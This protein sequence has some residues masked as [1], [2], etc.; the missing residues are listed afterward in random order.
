M[1]NETFNT[2]I[3]T[4]RS[5][6]ERCPPELSADLVDRGIVLAG[7]GALI[8]GLDIRMSQ[9]TGLPCIVAENAPEAVARGTG[10]VLDDLSLWKNESA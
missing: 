3:E 9:A 8:R 2:I 10:A 7:G 1:K 5:A 6:L 4:V